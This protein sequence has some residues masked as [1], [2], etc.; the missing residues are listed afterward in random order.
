MG[1]VSIAVAAAVE[2]VA[3]AEGIDVGGKIAGSLDEEVCMALG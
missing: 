1:L 3:V 2:P